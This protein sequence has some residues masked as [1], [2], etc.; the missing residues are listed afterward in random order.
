MLLPDLSEYQPNASMSGIKAQNGGA[1]I[2]RVAYG[3]SHGDN[4]FVG[5]RAA[6][7]TIGY[8]FLGLYHYLVA[9]QDPV[10][11]AEYFCA[12]VTKLQVGEIPILDMEEGTN[13]VARSNEWLNYVDSKLGLSTLPLNRKSWIYSYASFI[14]SMGLLPIFQSQRRSWVA[15]YSSTEPAIPHTLWQSTDGKS[16]S[17]L[18]DW[19]GAGFCDTNYTSHTLDDLAAMAY[20]VTSSVPTPVPTATWTEKLMQEL[21]TLAE[22]AVGPDVRTVQALLNAR[23]LSVVIDGDFGPN[24]K[25]AIESFQRAKALNSTGVVD[26]LTWTRLL[27][28]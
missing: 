15:A 6:A 24:T 13:C 22:G 26:Q 18:T 19:A 21:P 14:Q 11:Q 5:H 17:H 28:R 12:R 10:L 16:G 27:N 23:T 20:T 8:R 9:S 3:A 1:A 2:I 25:A 4:V 7:H